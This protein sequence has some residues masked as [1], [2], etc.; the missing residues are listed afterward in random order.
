M[1]SVQ[2][3]KVAI[4]TRVST[5]DQDTTLQTTELLEYARKRGWEP[6]M[7]EDHGIS[8]AKFDR[9]ALTRMMADVASGSVDLVLTWKLD[10]MG[11]STQHLAVDRMGRS[12]QHLA[13]IINVLLEANVGLVVPTQGIDTSAGSINPASK[14]QLNVLAAVAEFER[15]LIRE[16]TK[17]GMRAAKSKGVLL[18]RRTIVT[19]QQL[20]HAKMLVAAGNDVTTRHIAKAVGVSRGTAWRLK[21]KIED[22]LI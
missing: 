8:G 7:Y 21:R 11:R 20:A 19:E 12:T 10:R 15:D 5:D 3:R 18:G 2:P 16:R 9:P 1:I 22:G 17:A 14:L 6:V 13:G 4:Y